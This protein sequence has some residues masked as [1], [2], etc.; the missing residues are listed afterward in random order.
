MPLRVRANVR[1][2]ANVTPPVK[3]RSVDVPVNVP[4]ASSIA[5][6]L[7]VTVNAGTSSSSMVI[8]RCAP[9][10]VTTTVSASSS[11]TSS[12]AVTVVSTSVAP[13]ARVSVSEPTV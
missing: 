4:P 12:T 3:I 1:F 11:T 2:V 6:G 8:T 7:T 9:S 5:V 10:A 13:T